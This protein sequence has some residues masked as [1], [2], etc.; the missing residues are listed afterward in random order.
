MTSYPCISLTLRIPR[1]V[2]FITS[3][4][5]YRDRDWELEWRFGLELWYQIPVGSITGIGNQSGISFSSKVKTWR[6]GHE[7]RECWHFHCYPPSS[8]GSNWWHF[9]IEAFLPGPQDVHIEDDK[10]E[11]S[12]WATRLC[13]YRFCT[14]NVKCQSQWGAPEQEHF[15][16]FWNTYD[17]QF[18]C[19]KPI[20]EFR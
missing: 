17:L 19:A 11:V 14:F 15:A 1:S 20:S 16:S 12:G 18:T 4:G 9:W 6:R 7:F 13:L 10:D 2:N 3:F 5:K 8:T